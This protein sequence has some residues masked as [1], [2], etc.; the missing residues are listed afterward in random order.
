MVKKYLQNPFF[1]TAILCAFLFYSGIFSPPEENHFSSLISKDKINEVFGVIVNSPSKTSSGKYY[2]ALLK[3]SAVK[4]EKGVIS[5]ADGQFKIL[6]PAV[7]TE[8][9]LPGK[10]Y[11]SS[12]KNGTYIYESGGHFCFRGKFTNEGLFISDSS[13]F[14]GYGK[15]I[16]S[17]INYFRSLCR[18]QFK[19]MMYAWKDGGGLLLAL[20]SGSREYTDENLSKNFRNS[21]ISHILALSGMHLSLFSGL[22]VTAGNKIGKRRL[23]LILR[24]LTILL[25]VWFAGFSPSLRRAFIFCLLMLLNNECDC[26]QNDNT[27]ILCVCFLLHSSLFPEEISNIAFILSYAALAGI[28][29][30]SDFFSTFTDFVFPPSISSPFCAGLA[31]QVFTAP[32]SLSFF[33]MFSPAGVIATVV[34]SPLVTIFIYSGLFLI[35]LTMIFPFFLPVSDF[36]V[37]IQYNL[38]DFF[39]S[40]FAKFPKIIL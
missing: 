26:N 39:A 11:S 10:L 6:I 5:N 29:L 37:S 22:A 13:K 27:I 16:K 38:I 2:S 34:I 12:V 7:F 36:F 21:G 20:L 15:G 3:V 25:F 30:L 17:K 35:L 4:S 19:R 9:L 28:F 32:V 33:R 18:L 40:V 14:F 1:L 31:A 24:I 23:G 8:A